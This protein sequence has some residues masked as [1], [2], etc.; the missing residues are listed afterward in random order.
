MPATAVGQLGGLRFWAVMA[1]RMFAFEK[2]IHVVRLITRLDSE[3]AWPD[4]AMKSS[5]L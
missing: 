1:R 3:R 2:R 4:L 5:W